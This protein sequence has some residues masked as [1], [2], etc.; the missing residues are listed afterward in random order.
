[1]NFARAVGLAEKGIRVIDISEVE[2][3]AAPW[4]TLRIL[5][6]R[7][8]GVVRD[9]G[10]HIHTTEI[11]P[12]VRHRPHTHDHDEIIFVIEGRGSEHGPSGPIEVGPGQVIY[13]PAGVEHGTGNVGD[14]TL[15]LI[16]IFP[17]GRYKPE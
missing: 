15:K 11:K 2:P 16:V 3:T 9:T 8:G 6:D 1:V 5:F 12:G 10:V 7:E 14:E 13:I 17:T 4:G